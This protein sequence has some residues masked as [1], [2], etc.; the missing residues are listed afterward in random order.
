MKWRLIP[1][2]ESSG[3]IQMAIDNWLFIQHE[4]GQHPPTLRFYTWS[5]PTISIGRL[6]KQWPLSWHNLTWEKRPIELVRRST[7]GRAV[8]HQGDLTYGIVAP[9]DNRKTLEIYQQ[10]CQFLIKGW[11]YFGIELNYGTAKRGYIHNPS[12][13]NIATV[14]DLITSDGSKLIG[15]AQLRGKQ[16]ILQHGSMVL[17]TNKTLFQT[18]FNQTAPWGLGLLE[19]LPKNCCLETIIDILIETA[20]QCFDIDFIFQPLSSEEWQDVIKLSDSLK[21][22]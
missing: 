9:I 10:I 16:S 11:S 19:Q 22:Q 18:I 2:L 17:S 6:Q 21:V 13:F 7:G 15:S 20:K 3:I 14:S 8:L 5:S 12:C 1:P 4:R